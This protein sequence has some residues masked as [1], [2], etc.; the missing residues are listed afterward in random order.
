MHSL[1]RW[2][3]VAALFTCLGL[4][5]SA[6]KEEEKERK[7]SKEEQL[8]V[9]LTNEARKEKG[10]KPLKVNFLL[11]K[12]ATYYSGV[13]IKQREKAIKLMEKKDHVVHELDGKKVGD[14][15]DDVK[16]DWT[17]CGE[18]VA[19]AYA[20]DQMK[21]VHEGWMASKYHRDNILDKAFT[22]V[23]MAVVKHPDRK[24]WYITEVFG[25]TG[26]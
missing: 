1:H 22:E 6:D 19:A 10:L 20:A 18:N 15:L 4:C 23:G 3:A 9:D 7:L 21:K 8:L 24:E 25:S 14:R 2:F 12:S 26:K 5:W 16:Y 13:M 11:N 17:D